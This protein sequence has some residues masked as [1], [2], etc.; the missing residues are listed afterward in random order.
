MELTQQQRTDSQNKALHL[1]FELLAEE[2]NGA[3]LDMRK[4]L[5]PHVD[6]PWQ[7]ET[8]KEYLWRPVQQA[9]LL[10]DSTTDMTP[11]EV[12]KV[13]ETLNRHLGEKFGV[14]VEWPHHKDVDKDLQA[15]V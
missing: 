9:Q 6:I 3:G 7:K 10:K 13:Y 12:T 11:T 8:V 4:V 14:H 5:K 2:L 15:Q 1:W